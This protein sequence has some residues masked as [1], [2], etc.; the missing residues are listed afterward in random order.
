MG[1]IG[2]NKSMTDNCDTY[3]ALQGIPWVMRKIM[4]VTSP[5]VGVSLNW[6]TFLLFVAWSPSLL[7]D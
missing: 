2:Q 7:L 5:E 4:R 1:D 3:F 6:S